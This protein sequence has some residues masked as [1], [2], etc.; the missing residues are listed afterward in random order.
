MGPTASWWSSG[1]PRFVG[2]VARRLGEDADRVADQRSLAELNYVHSIVNSVHLSR[3]AF[4]KGDG[5]AAQGRIRAG[6][7]RQLRRLP[8]PTGDR[9]SCI[10]PTQHDQDR[11]R[12]KAHPAN[13]WWPRCWPTLPTERQRVQLRGC[14]DSVTELGLRRSMGCIGSCLDNAVAESP[15]ATLKASSSTASITAS[16]PKREPRS[17]AAVGEP[18]RSSAGALGIAGGGRTVTDPSAPRGRP[19]SRRRPPSR[20][21]KERAAL[22]LG[23]AATRGASNLAAAS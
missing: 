16:A 17:S 13:G 6:R 3:S 20:K 19:P 23:Q 12:P 10:H 22:L 8:L 15:F 9:P 14:V 7:S 11:C 1:L 18:Y 5:A 4:N 2:R 21:P